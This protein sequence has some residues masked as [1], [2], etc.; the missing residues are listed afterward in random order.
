MLKQLFASALACLCIAQAANAQTIPNTDQS[1]FRQLWNE[2][3]TPNNYRSA[4]GAPGHQYWQQKA[5][6]VINIKLDDK[7]RSVTGD[8]R[9]T[10]TN[11]SPDVLRYIWIQ[12]DQNIFEKNADSKLSEPSGFGNEAMSIDNLERMVYSDFKGGYR[13]DAVNDAAGKKLKYTCLLY[14]SDAADE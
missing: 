12:L 7:T 6:Y 8:E 10:Y 3:P 4:S 2:L 9:I 13:I 14:T 5:D 11:N 1:K